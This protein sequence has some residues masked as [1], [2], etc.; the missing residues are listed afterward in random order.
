MRNCNKP[1]FNRLMK[2]KLTTCNNSVAFLAVYNVKEFTSTTT[3][4]FYIFDDVNIYTPCS[5]TWFLYWE[6]KMSILFHSWNHFIFALWSLSKT[7]LLLHRIL[8][9]FRKSYPYL[10][11]PYPYIPLTNLPFTQKHPMY[12]QRSI[13][14]FFSTFTFR[15]PNQSLKKLRG[16]MLFLIREFAAL[17]NLI[18]WMSEIKSLFMK[19]WNSRL[20]L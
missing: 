9:F 7:S 12:L 18:K 14:S 8:T 19:Q 5:Y 13:T 6:K 1:D 17:M 15:R 3:G 16:C 4:H 10:P 2:L 11:T 20:F